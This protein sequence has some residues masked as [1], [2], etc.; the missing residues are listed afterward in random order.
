MNNLLQIVR[1]DTP[2]SG[3]PTIRVAVHPR[4]AFA[5]AADGFDLS[6]ATSTHRPR[7]QLL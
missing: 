1:S 2:R 6:A 7:D 4:H 3:G 5:A